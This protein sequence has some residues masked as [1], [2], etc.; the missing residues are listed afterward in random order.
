MRKL[1]LGLGVLGLALVAG[2]VTINVYFPKAA[3]EKA[4]DQFIGSV[5]GPAT[6]AKPAPKPQP[7]AQPGQSNQPSGPSAASVLG[8]RALDFLV[9]PAHATQRPDLRIHTPALDVIH[10]RMQQ[11]FRDQLAPLLDKGVIGFTAD[12]L[13]AVRDASSVPLAQ[14]SMVNT[15]VADANRDR[16]ALYREIANANGHPDWEADIRDTFAKLWVQKAHKGWYYRTA[17]GDWKRK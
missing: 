15:T 17:Q 4:A 9:P 14:R 13:V 12:G 6:D 10:K 7:D 11:R 8:M 1:L 5:I 3:A 2:C 16:V